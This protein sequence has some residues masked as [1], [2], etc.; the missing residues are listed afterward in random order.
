MFTPFAFVKSAAAAGGSFIS[1]SGGTIT[2]DGNF[3][4][5]TFTTVGSNNFVVHSTG[6]GQT[7]DYLLVAGGGGGGSY[8]GGGGGA[9][10]LIYTTGSAGLAVQT[11]TVV[12]GNGGGSETD[13][14]DSTFF[15][16]TAVKGGR[17]A[18]G[19]CETNQSAGT[20]GSG[21]GG[22][23]GTFTGGASGT[24]GQ[25]NSGGNV[26]PDTWNTNQGFV[27]LGVLIK[28]AITLSFVE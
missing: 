20:G 19:G 27:G 1:A 12:V 5:H 25:G 10:G 28:V 21:G 3:K 26:E 4:I 15:S 7:F 11:Y 23:S 6:S 18:R 24:A 9:G 8:V 2:T 22:G 13:G 14:Q 16:Q 17:G